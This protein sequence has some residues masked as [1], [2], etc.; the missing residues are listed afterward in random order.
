MPWCGY[1]IDTTSLEVTVDYWRYSDSDSTLSDT[2]TI[3]HARQPG[4]AFR[5]KMSQC[6][7]L[8]TVLVMAF[9]KAHFLLSLI[10]LQSCTGSLKKIVHRS[11]V[12]R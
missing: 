11:Y 2:L 4:R 3:E 6:A 5:S 10:M 7:H 12:E 1:F 8:L 9:P